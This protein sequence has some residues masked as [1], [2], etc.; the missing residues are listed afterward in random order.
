MTLFQK[1][2]GNW[3]SAAHDY[4]VVVEE[5]PELI[6]GLESIQQEIRYPQEAI[7]LGIEGR[8]YV[9]FIVNRNGDVENPKIIRGIGGGCDEAAIEAVRHARF[10]PGKQRGEPVPVLYSLPIIFR[11]SEPGE[12]G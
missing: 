2:T 4:F 11:L 9:Q 6:D 1:R 12:N 3:L 10:K 8:V 7:D 5:M